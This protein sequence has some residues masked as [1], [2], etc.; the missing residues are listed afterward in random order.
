MNKIKK[1]NAFTVTLLLLVVGT[2]L[3][4]CDKPTYGPELIK[5]HDY[6]NKQFPVTVMVF[7]DERK[8]NSYLHK[9]KLLD[10]EETVDGMAKW[11]LNKN[12]QSVMTRCTI[13]VVEPKGSK[14]YSELT[15]W[16]HELV[17]CVYGSFHKDGI[18]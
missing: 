9:E 4:S 13:Y 18:R 1:I 8:L 16:G 12:D 2:L 10:R 11:A 6:T 3:S 17:H 14:H 5:T 15:T 7:D